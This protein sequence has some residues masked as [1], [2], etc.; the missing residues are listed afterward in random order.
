VANLGVVFG[1]V[2]LSYSSST[3]PR[4]DHHAHKETKP[5]QGSRKE[6]CANLTLSNRIHAITRSITPKIPNLSIPS[7]STTPNPSS[8]ST[9]SH[10]ASA[11]TA[12]STI[13]SP[14]STSTPG[15]GGSQ[16]PT[17]ATP[18]P[19]P[20]SSSSWSY[21]NPSVPV[22]GLETLETE[23]FRLTCF[24]TL[25]GTKFLLFTDPA[26]PN[27][28]GVMRS[29]YELYADYVMKNPFYQLEMPVRCE[30]FDRGLGG[31]LRGRA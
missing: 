18:S 16:T 6:I 19:H 9:P 10:H 29:V 30:G 21:P 22:S 25:T 7:T 12:T 2:K 20:S 3:A 4:A 24:Q 14:S 8:S 23:K 28:E 11:S 17:A 5:R 15:G 26:M 13:L 31:F 1:R 27:V